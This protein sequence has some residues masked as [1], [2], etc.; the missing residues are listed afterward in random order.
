MCD[1][2]VKVLARRHSIDVYE[3]LYDSHAT[4]DPLV[5]MGNAI[6]TGHTGTNVNDLKICLIEN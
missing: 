1:A 5:K 4:R 3:I 6:F 2:S